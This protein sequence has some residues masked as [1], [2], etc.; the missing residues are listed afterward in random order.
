MAIRSIVTTPNPILSEQSLPVDQIDQGIKTL[1][2]DMIDTMYDQKGAGLAAVQIGVL[3]RI[4][5]MDLGP[6]KKKNPLHFINPEI[7][8]TSDETE[9]WEEGCLSVPG[10]YTNI[11]RQAEC[12]VKYLTLDG[13]EQE[14]H[15][16]GREAECVQHEIDHLDGKLF[17]D[18]LSPLRRKMIVKKVQKLSR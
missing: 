15:Y 9:T 5:V 3:K 18:Y 13:K 17:I 12:K 14:S 6:E 7:T 8:W 2:Q 1:V 16:K 4:F 10:Q 11:T